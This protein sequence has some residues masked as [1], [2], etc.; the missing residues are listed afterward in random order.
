MNAPSPFLW[1]PWLIL[2]HLVHASPAA[3]E[4]RTVDV[5]SLRIT[6]DT[7][8]PSRIA[9][10]YVPVRLD[11]TNLGDARVIEIVIEGMR[12]DRTMR[13]GPAQIAIRQGVR[14]ARLDRVRLSIPV[15]V[16]AEYENF[17][18]RI[19][20]GDRLVERFSYSNFQSTT[21]AVD[22]A[23]LIVANPGTAFGKTAAAL[24][25]TGSGRATSFVI[26]GPAT[27]RP[28]TPRGTTPHDLVLEPA[29]LPVTW[30]GYTSLR[31]VVIGAEEWAGLEDA[32]KGALL[33][34][35]ASGGDLI[36]VDGAAEALAGAGHRTREIAAD[37]PARGYF[38]GRIHRRTS[39]AMATAGLATALSE[40]AAVQ[41]P[42][43]AL[44]ASRWSRWN[45]ITARGFRFPI[46]GVAHV[47]VRAYLGILFVFT[48]LVGPVNYWLLARKRRQVLFVATAPLISALFIVVLA[49]YVVAGEGL[50]VSARAESFTVLDQARRQAATRATISLYAA[51]MTP[52]GG[53]Q[54][55]RDVAVYAIG[56][57]GGANRESHDMDLTDTQRFASGLIRARAPTNLEQIGFRPARERLTISPGPG[58]LSVVNGLGAAVKALVFRSGGTAYAL[59]Q[60]LPAGATALLTRGAPQGA[61]FVPADLPRS[62]RFA[63]LVDNLPEGAYFAVLERSPFWQP[64]TTGIVEYGSFHCVLG[65]VDGQP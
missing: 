65:W 45:V 61:T 25:R 10:G 27:S 19:D 39:D 43:W 56:P 41:D 48:L 54:F 13:T 38:F 63:H 16:S 1:I 57:D 11:I 23:A 3:G 26:S 60:S 64:G 42:D 30:L 44:P 55:P 28:A 22:A 7:D 14:L 8:W 12:F 40:A 37:G 52:S 6:V 20:E 29:R 53:L 50:H 24:A 59:T 2:F 58:G 5:E 18:V 15:P 9:P 33:T 32:Q 47:P 17:Q 49:G 31:A 34:W 51:G 35:T 4:Y 36:V 62:S 21:P 46:P